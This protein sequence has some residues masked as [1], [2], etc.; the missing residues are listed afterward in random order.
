MLMPDTGETDV[1]PYY[2]LPWPLVRWPNK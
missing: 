1:A 2:M